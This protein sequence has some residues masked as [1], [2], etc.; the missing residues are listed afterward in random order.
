MITGI[1]LVK[2]FRNFFLIVNLFFILI[3]FKLNN[4]SYQAK[5]LKNI[6][7]ILN[8]ANLNNDLNVKMFRLPI[9]NRHFFEAQ[10]FLN[11]FS[12]YV[13]LFRLF[14]H[15]YKVF[16]YNPTFYNLIIRNN[17]A[18]YKQRFKN[19]TIIKNQYL[20]YFNIFIVPKVI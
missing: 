11:I 8:N 2:I 5:C 15:L 7:R 18:I 9:I 17:Y 3:F 4:S 13:L 20:G 14:C 6:L 16:D 1:I 10:N 12:K 19:M